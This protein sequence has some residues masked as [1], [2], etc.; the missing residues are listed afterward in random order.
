MPFSNCATVLERFTYTV[1][2]DLKTPLVTI[3]GFLGFLEKDALAGDTE[4][5]KRDIEHVNAATETMGLLLAEL[6]ELSRIG[7]LMNPPEDIALNDLAREAL[8]LVHGELVARGVE[9]HGGR[10]WVE[11]EELGHGSTFWFTLP[12]NDQ[13]S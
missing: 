13:P 9:V 6:L 8:A 5:M 1:S 11:S 7:R 2:H 10:I 12:Q 3:K 4:R